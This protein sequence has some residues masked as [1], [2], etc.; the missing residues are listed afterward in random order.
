MLDLTLL[1]KDYR[2]K[3]REAERRILKA[4]SNGKD[5]IVIHHDDADGLSSAAITSETLRRLNVEHRLVC[6]EKLLDEIIEHIHSQEN[7]LIIY[8]DIGSPH[9]DEIAQVD[10]GKN[11]VIIL[12][13]HDPQVTEA[14]NVLDLN[15][16][17][18]NFKGETDFSGATC[19]YI[20]SKAISPENIDLSYLAIV[21][22]HELPGG[23]REFNLAAL[24]DS[25][26]NN[27]VS[28][29]NGNYLIKKLRITTKRLF[30]I[31]QV[32][33][34]V[35]YY[36][37]G[38]EMGVKVALN[39]LDDEAKKM[40][41]TLE[42]IRKQRNRMLLSRLFRGQLKKLR[43]VQWFNAGNIYEGLG[44]KTIGT[45]CSFISYIK[46]L[47][48]EN[49]YIVG[50]QPLP[51]RI[52]GL[53]VKLKKSYYKVSMRAPVKLREKIEEGK[54]PTVIEVLKYAGRGIGTAIDGHA[55]AASGIIE[56]DKISLFI[57]KVEEYVEKFLGGQ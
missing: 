40:H 56:A 30:S 4:K 47:V 2:A 37:G 34:S 41:D 17:L 23:F 54:M 10:N 21:G 12:D 53:D 22:S 29:K 38:P 9:A 36:K 27:I 16:E 45:F 51:P 3:L 50:F 31:L 14:E 24:E 35:G 6:I 42:A 39:G 19:C 7:R 28:E 18:F 44:V 46:R 1:P 5:V 55:F 43:Y 8:C 13:H 49:K 11:D 25:L 15:L 32:L 52:P 57:F 48:D 33:G 20:F 26:E